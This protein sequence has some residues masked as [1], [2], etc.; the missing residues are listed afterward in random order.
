MNLNAKT[1]MTV[2]TSTTSAPGFTS[3]D[4]IRM[5]VDPEDGKGDLFTLCCQCSF[6][7]SVSD[8]IPDVIP[9]KL[10]EDLVKKKAE[11]P[12][13]DSYGELAALITLKKILM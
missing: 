10:L 12:P 13:P 5:D 7:V 4:N 6:Y 8:V 9:V 11:N 1:H 2:I 3:T